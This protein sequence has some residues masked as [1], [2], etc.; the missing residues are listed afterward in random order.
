M[1]SVTKRFLLMWKEV[2][3]LLEMKAEWWGFFFV[4]GLYFC[5]SF[6]WMTEFTVSGVK[7]FFLY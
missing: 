1:P 5:C 7:Q 4:V 3:N 2:T 6:P